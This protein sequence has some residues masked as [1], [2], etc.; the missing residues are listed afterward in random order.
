MP[1]DL[2]ALAQIVT[3]AASERGMT[4]GTAESVTGGLVCSTLVG[5][6]GASA[7]VLGGVVAYDVAVK[8]AV[9]GVPRALL[10]A[11]GPVSHAVA[12]EMAKGAARVL[13]TDLAVATTGVAGPDWH[14]GHPPGTVVIA[15]AGH[16]VDSVTTWNFMGDRREVREAA[17]AVALEQV[18]HALATLA[19]G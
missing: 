4:V 16:G 15:V 9:L 3:S 5:V 12:V 6:P 1:A 8:H 11:E 14:D 10:D 2:A 17:T 19:Q 13:R 7:V 18:A